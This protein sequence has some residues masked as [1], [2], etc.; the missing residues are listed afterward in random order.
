MVADKPIGT[1]KGSK[2]SATKTFTHLSVSR[3]AHTVNADDSSCADF[4]NTRVRSFAA[5]PMQPAHLKVWAFNLYEH[6]F[7]RAGTDVQRHAAR[8]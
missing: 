4:L 5:L 3:N 2:T 6:M 8:S 7:Q 1:A